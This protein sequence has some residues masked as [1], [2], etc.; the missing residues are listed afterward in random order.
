V[1]IRFPVKVEIALGADITADPAT[2]SW[3][4]ITAFCYVREGGYSSRRG[5]AN[6]QTGVQP[7]G[8]SLLLN[9]R[10]GRFSRLNPTGPYYGQLAKNTPV[11]VS[12]NP[13]SGYVVRNTGLISELPTEWDLSQSDWWVNVRADDPLRRLTQGTMPSRSVLARTHLAP[14]YLPALAGYWPCEDGPGAIVAAEIHGRAPLSPSGTVEFGITTDVPVGSEAAA[15][16]A[17]GS[18]S[19]GAIGASANFDPSLNVGGVRF[20]AQCQAASVRIATIGLSNGLTLYVVSGT[21]TTTLVRAD[22]G[23]TVHSISVNTA[24]GGWHSF[25]LG[26]EIFSGDLVAQLDIDDAS[27][28]SGSLAT[29]TMGYVTSLKFNP[30]QT[31]D[32]LAIMH[33]AVTDATRPGLFMNQLTGNVGEMASQRWSGL[34]TFAEIFHDYLGQEESEAL[35]DFPMG[36]DLPGSVFDALQECVDA[37]EGV[38]YPTRDGVLRLDTVQDRYNLAP[39]LE[40]DYAQRQIFPPFRPADD[41]QQTRNDVT[42]TLPSGSSVRVVDETGP[43][44]VARIGRYDTRP[45]RNLETVDLALDHAG[46][47]VNL[48]TVE[49]YR[50]PSVNLKLHKP[51]LASLL[52]DIVAVDIGHR[53]TIANPPA[54]NLVPDLIDL[55][56][57]GINERIDN[58]TWMIEF[59]C[60]PYRPFTVFEV[61]ATGN[62]GR[63]DTAGCVLNVA[64]DSDDTTMTVCTTSG[65]LW[66]TTAGRPGDFPFD[67]GIG[68]E[69]ATVTAAA[70]VSAPTFV[71]AGTAAHANNASVTPGLPAG[72]TAGDLLLVFAAIRN[73]GTGT[74]DTPAGY[75]ELVS[76]G[77]MALFGKIHDGSE[78]DPTVSF[79]NGAAN[80]DTSAQMAALRGMCVDLDQI[81]VNSSTKLNTSAQDITLP[82]LTVR[83]DR[84]VVLAL[85]WKQDDWTSVAALSGFTEIGEPDTTTGDDQGLVWDY[86]IQTTATDVGTT[87]FT[88]TGGASAISR[89]VMVALVG[90][91]QAL[92]VTR[93]VNTVAK[94]HSAGAA[95][96][97]WRAPKVAL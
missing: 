89:G 93:S 90:G 8:F 67:I 75:A 23:A 42:V 92:T 82:H 65:P 13:G 6:W 24:D 19:V 37:C 20:N 55:V 71:A 72:V 14:T 47:L 88:V 74:V 76:F 85:G 83:Q 48:G 69:R 79:S 41:D 57:E 91:T 18:L 45:D 81:V 38:M 46:W 39:T 50:Y 33:V 84:C 77:N 10:D 2:W 5:R 62:D 43:L 53:I 26:L 58:Y 51:G 11:R 1:S 73:S 78:S 95:L 36:P 3:T 4:D 32:M 66:I 31:A 35:P 80:A 40:L 68:G 54:G 61:E 27:P 52:D 7:S 29:A 59:V 49:E 44:G 56:V 97:L 63:A 86:V 64:V 30:L 12:A 16:I 96:R 15:G 28:S 87:S 34:C 9:N 25:S 17:S 21:S 94:S 60:G 22:T 70:A